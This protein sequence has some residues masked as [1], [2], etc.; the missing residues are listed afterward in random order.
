VITG[1]RDLPPVEHGAFPI[2]VWRADRAMK[3][4]DIAPGLY[5]ILEALGRGLPL[6]EAIEVAFQ[7]G[8]VDPSTASDDL[9]EWFRLAVE[10]GMVGLH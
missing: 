1:A 6:A 10:W 9:R 3:H 8:W 5:G 7:R 2:A 4:L